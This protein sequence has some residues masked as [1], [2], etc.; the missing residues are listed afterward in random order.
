M[1]EGG[2]NSLWESRSCERQNSILDESTNC[3]AWLPGFNSDFIFSTVWPWVS[4]L[5]SPCLSFLFCD[6]LVPLLLVA[7]LWGFNKWIHVKHYR[8]MTSREPQVLSI[9]LH[10]Q[11]PFQ[12]HVQ[13][14]PVTRNT[15]VMNV[16]SSTLL[17]E[18]EGTNRAFE[19][20]YL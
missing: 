10:H 6:M 13:T 9:P 15:V 16:G 18:K 3:G 12:G 17:Q 4:Y 7:L 2:W 19:H 20:H 1:E 8:T 11:H 14:K 5:T